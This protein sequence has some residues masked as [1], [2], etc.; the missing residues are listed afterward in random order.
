MEDKM[1]KPNCPCPACRKKTGRE[2]RIIKLRMEPE[3][4]EWLRGEAAR[5]GSTLTE[6]IEGGLRMKAAEYYEEAGDNLR[7]AE[8]EGAY[9]KAQN[10]ATPHEPGY[11]EDAKRIQGKIIKALEEQ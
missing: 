1:H 5:T 8:A 11:M 2:K 9:R 7:G 4:E 3:L 6:I 10:A